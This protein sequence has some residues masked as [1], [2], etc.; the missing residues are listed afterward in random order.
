MT[1]FLFARGAQA[2]ES[3]L[4]EAVRE[5]V[6]AA[7][8]EPKKL[9]Q[10]VYV[11][12]PSRELR[13]HLAIRLAHASATL[14]V[15]VLSL[16]ALALRLHRDAGAQPESRSAL[17]EVFARRAAELQP[18][19]RE[20]LDGLQDG[21]GLAA[22]SVRDL[23]SARVIDGSLPIVRAAKQTAQ[24]MREHQVQRPGDLQESAAEH[25]AKHLHARALLVHGFADATGQA[26]CLLR[27]L[28]QAGAQFVIDLPPD[29][30]DAGRFDRGVGFV[31][32]FVRGLGGAL[33]GESS[34]PTANEAPRMQQFHAA[35]TEDEVR[36]VA[37]RVRDLLAQGIR[38]D[39][40]GVVVRS[41]P[42]YA[43]AVRRSFIDFAVPFRGGQAP[44]SLFPIHRRMQ[45]ALAVLREQLDC[46]VD[47]WLDALAEGKRDRGA[48]LDP[49]RVADL[50]LAFRAL[51]LGRLGQV[52]S[53]DEAAALR[54]RPAFPLPIRRG[55]IETQPSESDQADAL[56]HA[57]ELAADAPT[58]SSLPF[59]QQYRAHRR[60]IPAG[61]FIAAFG[62]ARALR[63]SLHDW[64]Q[65]ASL[66]EHAL[67]V[68]RLLK[69]EFGWRSQG[70]D[71]EEN[72]LDLVRGL[73][74]VDL[75]PCKRSEFLLMLE[76]EARNFG[77]RSLG[78]SA[79]VSVLD[80]TQARART[81]S[82]LFVLGVNRGVLPRVI[83]SDPVFPDRE[84]ASLRQSG[85]APD[86]HLAER[87][88]Q[89][90][91]Y[92]FA[93]LC[94][95]T[96]DLTLS[97]QRAD[98]DGKEQPPSPF[99]Q[100][101][102]L[103]P[104]CEL[105]E[106]RAD[107]VPRL[108]LELLA[109]PH[110]LRTANELLIWAGLHGDRAVWR[111]LLPA[112]LADAAQRVHAAEIMD[113][114]G[115]DSTQTWNHQLGRARAAILDE[116]EPDLRTA[117]GRQRASQLSPWSGLL[118]QSLAGG[119][120]VAVTRL[121]RFASCAWQA[122]L[123][124]HLHLEAA[125]DPLA[126]L[127]DLDAA[128]LG[129]TVHKALETLFGGQS[130]L[131]KRA[132]KVA[133]PP[134]A[135][136]VE[137][138]QAAAQETAHENELRMPGLIQ[139]LAQRAQPF[140]ERALQLEF[141]DSSTLAVLGCEVRQEIE[142]KLPDGSVRRLSFLADRA[143]A[144]AD[145]APVFTDYKTAR[146]AWQ[147]A[148]K[149]RAKKLAEAV[150]RG[151]RLQVA[152]YAAAIDG[153]S[154]RYLF[155]RSKPG[156]PREAYVAMLHHESPAI[157]AFREVGGQLMAAREAGFAFPRMEKPDGSP[158]RACDWCELSDAC[159]RHDSGARRRLVQGLDASEDELLHEMWQLPA[160]KLEE[161]K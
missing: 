150:L 156:T 143:D 41:M 110:R 103:S 78:G 87:G 102:W 123:G 144:D 56:D 65:E 44:A 66:A 58:Q 17:V 26:M 37:H 21:M 73:G 124:Q 29:P 92:L 98:E 31:A 81:F 3:A 146:P 14:G 2:A 152:A 84:R 141:A 158:G 134:P 105:E 75:G 77:A 121:E 71:A 108:R 20:R 89:E 9:A 62:A 115:G 34:V 70:L 157:E 82:H 8:R 140:V 47:R 125:P 107:A 10:P 104:Q 93:Q 55:L 99:L 25:V 40:I 32:D 131:R 45:A 161:E 19:L 136:V 122:F 11:V 64:P 39:E 16:H 67:F 52:A 68:E 128:I 118:P 4:L 5:Q 90:E 132:Q 160:R 22:S 137:H 51:G 91:R 106:D 120:V 117:E 149:T 109:A 38:A 85:Q 138:V 129:S 79:G 159:L 46:P 76:R 145:G 42:A 133:E 30:A 114:K 154:G 151:E 60:S 48:G 80:L 135:S 95:A 36:E 6:E 27:A 139:A 86:L 35:G 126:E 119:E 24:A 111:T 130:E 148:A 57:D 54:D 28:K 61:A 13:D 7:R 155:L 96:S 15:E 33:P 53:F 94:S 88:H 100:R 12:V 97:W 63:R 49:D 116:Y 153:A 147:Q 72:W 83:Q 142:L 50:R 23:L 113:A 69:S 101:L 74:E 1:N 127:P 59:E 112:V 18:E 43:T